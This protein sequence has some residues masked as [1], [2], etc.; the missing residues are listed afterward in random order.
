VWLEKKSSIDGEA[1]SIAVEIRYAGAR[2]HAPPER[3]NPVA[4]TP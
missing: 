2:V 4:S 3:K 1:R